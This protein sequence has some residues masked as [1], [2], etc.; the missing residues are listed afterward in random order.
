[1]VSWQLSSHAIVLSRNELLV[2]GDVEVANS[3]DVGTEFLSYGRDYEFLL[4]RSR[5]VKFNLSNYGRG[6]LFGESLCKG[7]SVVVRRV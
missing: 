5:M 3:S 1:M 7:R 4:W 6:V 2:G